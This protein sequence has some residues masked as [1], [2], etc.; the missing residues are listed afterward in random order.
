MTEWLW[1]VYAI[2]YAERNTRTR[3][4][5]F[6]FDACNHPH[7]MDYFVWLLKSGEH[8]VLVDTGYD[9]A[10]AR[11]RNRPVLRSQARPE[12]LTSPLKW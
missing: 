9:A 7:A 12:A 10:E 1:E 4:D 8:L 3:F 11:A 2:K 5:S 6:M